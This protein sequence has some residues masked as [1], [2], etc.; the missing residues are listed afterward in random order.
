MRSWLELKI[1]QGNESGGFEGSIITEGKAR[2][3]GQYWSNVYLSEYL[4]A[5]L[6]KSVRKKLPYIQKY[7]YPHQI[8]NWDID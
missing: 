7:H 3:S 5:L 1:M 6:R 2:L 4:V 8:Y